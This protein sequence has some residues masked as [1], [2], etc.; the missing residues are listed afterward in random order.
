MYYLWFI[1]EHTIPI[2]FQ[3]FANMS[4]THHTKKEIEG[5]NAFRKY[6]RVRQDV[7][8]EIQTII[9]FIKNELQT[10]IETN[11]SCKKPN[12]VVL[13]EWGWCEK[14][15]TMNPMEKQ[16]TKSNTTSENITYLVDKKT[17]SVNITKFT[18]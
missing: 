9:Y 14:L 1:S 17:I 5:L 7:S 2:F 18:H 8:N 11:V 12:G 3:E 10:S 16:T 15:I 13:V 6:S 4:I